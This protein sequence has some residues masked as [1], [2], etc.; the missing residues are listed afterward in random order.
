MRTS[1]RFKA[2]SRFSFKKPALPQNEW[3]HAK[4]ILSRMRNDT[5][6]C[7]IDKTD[8][9]PIFGHMTKPLDQHA[10]RPLRLRDYLDDSTESR[11]VLAT[12]AC[13]ASR[14]IAATST[15]EIAKQ[16]KLHQGNIHY[17]FR[18]K[19]ALMR[20]VLELL[21]ENSSQNIAALQDK[22]LTPSARLEMIIDLGFDLTTRRRDEFVTLIACWAH[23]VV[24]GREWRDIYRRTFFGFQAAVERLIR[25]GEQSGEFVRGASKT[26]PMLL[27]SIVQGIGLQL[28]LSPSQFNANDV[29]RT[30]KL[31]FRTMLYPT[32]A[33]RPDTK[34]RK[35]AGTRQSVSRNLSADLERVR[36]PRRT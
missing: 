30:A 1:S 36:E 29:K 21:Y 10:G 14:G 33:A 31:V 26:L 27:V 7:R 13:I 28:A 3:R 32:G 18:S 25:E 5:R 22:R 34:K 17:Y 12:V 35:R 19:D 24:S 23:A 9:W 6:F 8:G 16:A 20:R 4:H 2:A 11:I 15:H